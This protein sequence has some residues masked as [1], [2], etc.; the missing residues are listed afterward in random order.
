MI[1]IKLKTIGLC[2]ITML[3]IEFS[4]F[5][6]QISKIAF[7][8]C[9]K[10]DLPQP[11][12]GPIGLDKPDVFLWLGDNVYGDTDDMELLKSKYD[13][14][15][16]V[17]GYR[18]LKKSAKVI[19]VW[20]DHDY[21][22]NDGGKFY[23]QKEASMELM[24]DFLDEAKDSPRRK[25]SGVYAVHEFGGGNEKVKVFLL[26]ARYNRDSLYRE[27]GEYLPNLEGSILG[28]EQ[29][30]WLASE[31]GKSKAQVN[32]I[33]SGIQFIPTA[34]PFEKWENFPKERER[35]FKLIESSKA[36]NPVLISGDRHIAEISRLKDSRFPNALYEITSSGMTHV[37]KTYKEEYNPYRVGGLI[38]SL[39]Y[40]LVEFDW[41]NSQ[42]TYQIK[43]EEGQVYLEQLIQ[44]RD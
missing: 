24:L 26:D 17:D 23:A 4:S 16:M 34:H 32:I 27:N 12:W 5:A 18:N 39:H 14:Q 2:I 13:A 20:D 43:G 15:N 10:H 7:G 30:E 42:M 8:S 3:A 33:A 37:W 40:G 21:G 1:T 31:L 25:Q 36:K 19:G 44:I 41:E 6:Q 11:L 22:I 9:N 29:W 35:L 28:E 38:A